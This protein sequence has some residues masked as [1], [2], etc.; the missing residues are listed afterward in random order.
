[1][2]M[3]EIDMSEHWRMRVQVLEE[4]MRELERSFSYHKKGLREPEY[5]C[6]WLADHKEYFSAVGVL[7]GARYCPACGGYIW[8]A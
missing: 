8:N 3:P 6:S 1:M 5:C 7:K 2:K 4:K